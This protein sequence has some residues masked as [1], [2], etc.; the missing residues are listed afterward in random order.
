MK[1]A[2]I[3]LIIEVNV[4]FY[5]NVSFNQNTDNDIT[6]FRQHG[7]TQRIID[8]LYL[9]NNRIFPTSTYP[10]LHPTNNKTFQASQNMH[11]V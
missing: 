6:T 3:L 2:I 7:L 5:S 11:Q 4:T 9:D 10:Y 1:T 8:T